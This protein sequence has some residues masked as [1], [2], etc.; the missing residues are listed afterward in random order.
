MASNTGNDV[1]VGQF[2]IQ[3]PGGGVGFCASG[4]LQSDHA[5]AILPTAAG[6]IVDAP[7]VNLP[8]KQIPMWDEMRAEEDRDPL[9]YEAIDEIRRQG[10]ASVSMLQRKMRIGYT[11]ASRLIE[12]IEE[13]GI[14]GPP[15]PGTG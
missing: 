11:R 1:E 9:L 13:Q 3:I 12:A 2:D 14:I 10:R 15:E 5:L 4:A 7:P 8:L 6:G